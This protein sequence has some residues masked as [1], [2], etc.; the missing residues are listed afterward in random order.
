VSTYTLDGAT[1]YG[2]E[3]SSIWLA[4]HM[5]Q[6]VDRG[7]AEDQ[8]RRAKRELGRSV[9]GFGYAREWPSAW[10]GRA[11]VDSGPV[12]PGLDVS[13]GSSGLYLVAARAFGDH[14]AERELLTTLDFAAFPIDD[15]TGLHYGASNQVGDA[16]LL[17]ALVL[18]PAWNAG[19]GELPP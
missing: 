4:A 13:A 8:Y 10:R 3:G 9:L 18:G 1:I 2:P 19:L 6:L 15:A 12:I 11:D 5:L 16:V 14:D 17:Y 7:F